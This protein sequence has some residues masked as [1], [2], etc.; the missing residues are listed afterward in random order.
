M[1]TVQDNRSSTSLSLWKK[2]RDCS[3]NEFLIAQMWEIDSIWCSQRVAVAEFG[4]WAAQSISRGSWEYSWRLLSR[5]HQQRYF[6]PAWLTFLPKVIQCEVIRA[7]IPILLLEQSQGS[8]ALT[9][10]SSSRILLCFSVP[11]L[12]GWIKIH[13][14]LQEMQPLSLTKIHPLCWKLPQE[15]TWSF[16][17]RDKGIAQGNLPN[18]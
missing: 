4:I 6:Y 10:F 1:D 15:E 16:P 11:S 8:F 2:I 14:Q 13:R 7:E 12:A 3:R 5:A 17:Q 9:Y 18:Y